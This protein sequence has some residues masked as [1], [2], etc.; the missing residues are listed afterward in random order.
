MCDQK[1]LDRLARALRTWLAR[2][3]RELARSKKPARARLQRYLRRAR[4]AEFVAEPDFWEALREL[5]R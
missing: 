3:R 1:R 2:E 4:I 5:Q